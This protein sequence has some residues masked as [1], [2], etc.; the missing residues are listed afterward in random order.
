MLPESALI[1]P[2]TRFGK[3]LRSVDYGK[4]PQGAAESLCYLSDKKRCMSSFSIASHV[5]WGLAQ[6][7]T[8]STSVFVSGGFTTVRLAV[9]KLRNMRLENDF[10]PYMCD[11]AKRIAFNRPSQSLGNYISPFFI[12]SL[13]LGVLTRVHGVH[14]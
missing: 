6:R 7:M 4:V 2:E 9:W 1:Q 5:L 12:D 3:S 13:H 8:L 11:T 10:L 14:A